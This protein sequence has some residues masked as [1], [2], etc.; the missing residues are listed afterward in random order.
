MRTIEE[1][2]ALGYT[3]RD[4]SLPRLPGRLREWLSPPGQPSFARPALLVI[5]G[6]AGL[7]YAWGANSAN[8]E[9]FYG[10]AARSMSESWHDFLF[11]AFDPRGTVTVDKLPGALWMQALSLRILGF[12]VWAV[13]L[14]QII[15]GLDDLGSLPGCTAAGRPG[16]RLGRSGGSGCQPGHDCVGAR[17]RIRLAADLADGASR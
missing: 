9:P 15:E 5:A 17:Q 6:L 14:P 12:H 11:G 16:G 13:V 2:A 1:K 7:A 3:P 4:F 10:A 8:L